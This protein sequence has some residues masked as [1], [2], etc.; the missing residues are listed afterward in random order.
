MVSV[1]SVGWVGGYSRRLQNAQN[2]IIFYLRFPN[3][4]SS[5]NQGTRERRM[6]LP[7]TLCISFLRVPGPDS[8]SCCSS[9]WPLEGGVQVGQ[10][11]QFHQLTRCAVGQRECS[12]AGC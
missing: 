8:S 4:E 7:M 9:M 3:S 11:Q 10:E 5:K 1:C 2:P 12:W 6:N